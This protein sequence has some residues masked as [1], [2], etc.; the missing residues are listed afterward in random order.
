MKRPLRKKRVGFTLIEAIIAAAMFSFL[1]IAAVGALV[2]SLT[3]YAG[4]NSSRDNQQAIRNI[5][6]EIGR[7][8]EFSQDMKVINSGGAKVLCVKPSSQRAF[9][10]FTSAVNPADYF[11]PDTTVRLLRKELTTAVTTCAPAIA[12]SPEETALNNE[13]G[14][15]AT[16]AAVV[17]AESVS[18]NVFEPTIVT[19][20]P[21]PGSG[22]TKTYSVDLVLGVKRKGPPVSLF[23]S[24]QKFQNTLTVHVAFFGLNQ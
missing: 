7:R 4:A 2:N 13:V 8:A 20:T 6:E 16:G 17:S 18:V 1:L 12:G 23:G 22:G 14:T 11:P 3:I 21:A 10:Y 24:P 5:T 15:R 19:T 9:L